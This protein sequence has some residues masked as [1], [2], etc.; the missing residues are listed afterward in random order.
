M[1]KLISFLTLAILL[2]AGC[3]KE[4]Q[5][6]TPEPGADKGANKFRITVASPNAEVDTKSTKS[7]WEEGDVIRVYFKDGE[8]DLFDL[9]EENA[10]FLKY[11]G[12]EWAVANE[13]E[14]TLSSG[15]FVAIYAT[16]D[17]RITITPPQYSSERINFTF[18]GEVL[19]QNWTE[20]EDHWGVAGENYSTEGG[21]ISL[22]LSLKRHPS[23]FQIVI[24]GLDDNA[25]WIMLVPSD[26]WGGSYFMPAATGLSAISLNG[27]NVSVESQIAFNNQ[28]EGV[29]TS[30]GTTFFM[31]STYTYYDSS[32]RKNITCNTNEEYGKDLDQY[33]IMIWRN[34]SDATSAYEYIIDRGSL[35]S[36]AYQKTFGP[37]MHIELPAFDGDAA[38][39]VYWKPC[40]REVYPRFILYDTVDGEILEPTRLVAKDNNGV[41][42]PYENHYGFIKGLMDK[43]MGYIKFSNYPRT[44]DISWEKAAPGESTLS[45]VKFASSISPVSAQRMFKNCDKLESVDFVNGQIPN[46]VTS[47]KEMFYGCSSLKSLSVFSIQT[48]YGVD[49]LL[50][51]MSSVFYGCESLTSLDLNSLQTKSVT[52]MSSLFEGCANLR[53]LN[54]SSF[55]TA[56]VE[57]MSNM[58]KGCSSMEEIPFPIHF[59][60][61][62]VS[63]MSGM[64]ESCSS[65]K[66]LD[67]SL[68]AIASTTTL[69]DM[70]KNTSS[71]KAITLG[72]D[73]GTSAVTEDIFSGIAS[74]GVLTYPDGCD[75]SAWLSADFGLGKYGW[76]SSTVA[77]AAGHPMVDL[78][79][80]VKWATTDLGSSSPYKS[81]DKYSWGETTAFTSY[82]NYT[83]RDVVDVL[84]ESADAAAVNWGEGWR[85]PTIE[86]MSE[87]LYNCD[88]ELIT[89]IESFNR[90]Y[91][92]KVSGKGEHSSDYIY[93]PFKDTYQFSY[94]ASTGNTNTH[95]HGIMGYGTGSV[96][97]AVLYRED[98][99]PIRAVHE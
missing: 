94:W 32:T 82:G 8:D 78:G 84:P 55:N 99:H 50:T 80:S 11:D 26:T 6:V 38:A 28:Q 64:F 63:D 88:W 13:P 48:I 33:R 12:S 17:R 2:L 34:G 47:I 98:S 77:A 10:L 51:D 83:Y 39:P 41:D 75:Y 30:D 52:D 35:G 58:F 27:S 53:S 24:P 23:M 59:V 91:Y 14:R 89:V 22:K 25:D 29:K 42:M 81:G 5:P 44:L 62:N 3:A 18:A 1:K 87:L 71:L 15:Q 74:N 4:I 9:T 49:P 40:E 20:Y 79:L 57:N 43:P 68:F 90:V 19:S 45:E 56:K 37:N 95:S 93:L 46:T 7:S 69:T 92:W 54:I 60:T 65:I 66:A 21:E 85:M 31:T 61:D 16:D 70:F 97:T 86:E 72:A 76:T 67:L 96:S 73:T 36:G